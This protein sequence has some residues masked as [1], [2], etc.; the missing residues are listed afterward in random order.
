MSR[1]SINFNTVSPILAGGIFAPQVWDDV[2]N[3]SSVLVSLNSIG[4]GTQLTLYQSPDRVNVSSTEILNIADGELYTNSFPIYSRFFK[5][6]LDNTTVSNQTA[7]NL[8]VIYK[9]Q[10]VLS[11]GLDVDANIT[12]QYLTTRIQGSGGETL[13]ATNAAL[14]TFITNTTAIPVDISGQSVVVSGTVTIPHLNDDDDSILDSGVYKPTND[15]INSYFEISANPVNN[16]VLYYADET[17]GADVVVGGVSGWQF[18]S[19]LHPSGTKNTKINWYMYQPTTDVVISDLTNSPTNTYYTVINNVGIE[20]PMIY[21][22]TKPTVPATKITGGLGGSS[23][24][25]SKFVYQATQAGTNGEYLLYVGANPTTIRT[26]IP[27]IRLSQLDILCLG[28][29]QTNEIV[30]SASLQTSSNI[31]S[32]AGNFSLTMTK[33]GVVIPPVNTPLK[34]DA[35]GTLQVQ[36]VTAEASLASIDAKITGLR[37][38]QTLWATVSTGAGGFSALADLT[39]VAPTNLTFYGNSNLPTTFTVQFSNDG[40]GW[41][42]SQYTHILTTAGDWGF[43]IMASPF[44]VRLTSSANV[45]CNAILNYA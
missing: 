44:Y 1:E 42:S 12:N 31:V 16:V 33:F 7:L 20:F 9:S 21:I 24:Y 15:G 3:Y 43:S 29:L 32:P 40:T 8:Q 19:T 11:S 36:D 13:A 28:T 37:G 35:D 6:R 39:D 14:N 10:Y 26:D 2:L 30:L 23:W 5:L 22:Y 17:Q 34:V 4:A 25:Q 27:H 41:Y 38:G 18:I 45:S